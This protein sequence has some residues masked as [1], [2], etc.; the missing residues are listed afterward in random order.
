MSRGSQHHHGEPSPILTPTAEPII[1]TKGLHM[2]T[3]NGTAAWSITFD[4]VHGKSYR[5]V[6]MFPESSDRDTI[7]LCGTAIGAV[8]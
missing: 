4:T 7:G 2:E 1:E 6:Y 5:S 8:D 3:N